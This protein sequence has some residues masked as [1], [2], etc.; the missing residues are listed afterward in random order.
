M[1][2]NKQVLCFACISLQVKSL[3]QG[4]TFFFRSMAAIFGEIALIGGIG[5]TLPILKSEISFTVPEKKM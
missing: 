5:Y 1:S 3:Q 2:R 4:M